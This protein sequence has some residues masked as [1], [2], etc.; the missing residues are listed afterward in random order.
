MRTPSPSRESG[1]QAWRVT[2][3]RLIDF[4]CLVCIFVS[5]WVVSKSQRRASGTTRHEP[6][7]REPRWS[8]VVAAASLSAVMQAADTLVMFSDYQCDGCRQ[9]HAKLREWR[10]RETLGIAVGVVHYPLAYHPFAA[11][12][13]RAALCANSVG[14][15]DRAHTGLMDSATSVDQGKLEFL[16]ALLPESVRR[17]F[18]K[19]VSDN[20]MQAELERHV[21]VSE[22]IGLTGTP[23]VLVNGWRVKLPDGPSTLREWVLRTREGKSPY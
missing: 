4:L 1:A 13:A 7:V 3:R 2:G 10:M 12:S 9:L 14:E 17:D 21:T 5:L 23:T 6:S 19:C 20:R 8:E 15:F 22:A 18:V 16:A 11:A